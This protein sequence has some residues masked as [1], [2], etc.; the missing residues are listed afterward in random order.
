MSRI[1]RNAV[2]ISLA[3]TLNVSVLVFGVFLYSGGEPIESVLR[4]TAGMLIILNL[5][6]FSINKL[7][8]KKGTSGKKVVIGSWFAA[9]QVTRILFREQPLFDLT[10]TDITGLLFF[11]AGGAYFIAIGMREEIAVKRSAKEIGDEE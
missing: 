5:C 8:D 2:V 9:M 6:I 11:I 4:I 7:R 10:A 3:L 1:R